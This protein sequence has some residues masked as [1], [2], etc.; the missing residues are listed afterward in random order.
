MASLPS[1]FDYFS[2]AAYE[3]GVVK[4]F[5]EIAKDT[6]ANED[7]VYNTITALNGLGTFLGLGNKTD[8]LALTKQFAEYGGVRLCTEVCIFDTRC[9]VLIMMIESSFRRVM[10]PEARRC[11]MST[12]FRG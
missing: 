5:L 8:R 6:R 12:R 11:H 1:G 9:L 2:K 4:A 7:V 10:H 3:A